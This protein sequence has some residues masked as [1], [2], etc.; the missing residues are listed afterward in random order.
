MG[1][2][3]IPALLRADPG[4][5]GSKDERAVQGDT[6]VLRDAPAASSVLGM[7]AG[8][9]GMGSTAMGLPGACLLLGGLST[10]VFGEQIKNGTGT[11]WVPWGQCHGPAA[12]P[13]VPPSRLRWQRIWLARPRAAESALEGDARL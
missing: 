5:G 7:Q 10:G 3:S 9:L 6:G 2:S 13:A 12:R 8:G 11:L 1:S 4:Y